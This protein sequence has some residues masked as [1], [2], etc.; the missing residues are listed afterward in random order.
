MRIEEHPIL[1]SQPVEELI[2]IW[3]DGRPIPARKGEPIAAALAA[4]GIR[5]LRKTAR[6]GEPRGVF[7][8]IGQCTDCAMTVNGQPNVR[9]CVT[10]AEE[11]MVVE[12]QEGCGSL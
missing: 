6:R 9:T 5:V 3:V 10:M 11:N 8:G 1:G 7:C 12:T 4:Q 2:T